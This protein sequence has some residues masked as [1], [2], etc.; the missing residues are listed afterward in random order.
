MIK[1][2][3]LCF[4]QNDYPDVKM[5]DIFTSSQTLYEIFAFDSIEFVRFIVEIENIIDIKLTNPEI[6]NM[7]LTFNEFFSLVEYSLINTN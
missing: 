4:I 1:E 2:K 5:D 3:I 7:N 6:F